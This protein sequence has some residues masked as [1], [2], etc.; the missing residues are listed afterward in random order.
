MAGLFAGGAMAQDLLAGV[1]LYE[2]KTDEFTDEV[3]YVLFLKSDKVPASRG[4]VSIIIT[5]KNNRTNIVMVADG[6]ILKSSN[7]TSDTWEA[8]YRLDKLKASKFNAYASRNAFFPTPLSAHIPFIKEMFNHDKLRVRF[9]TYDGTRET[10][11]FKITGT[12]NEI[13]PI[14]EACNW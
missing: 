8:D 4:E 7:D 13:K 10:A 12:E 1:W 9:E 5:C 6:Y 14:R 3:S 11:T 2:K